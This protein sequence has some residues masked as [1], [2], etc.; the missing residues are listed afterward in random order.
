MLA[1]GRRL[2]PT[3]LD[4]G[5]GCV[6]AD[7]IVRVR[8]VIHGRVQ[9]VWFR[10][11][12]AERAQALGVTGWVR[13]LADGGVEAVFEGPESAVGEA[14]AFVRQGPPRAEVT[15]CEVTWEQPRSESGFEIVG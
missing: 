7:D 10:Q 3:P 2:G 9:G 15:T 5:R 6:V 12:T 13:N 14:V 8:A 4:P 1:R 11:S